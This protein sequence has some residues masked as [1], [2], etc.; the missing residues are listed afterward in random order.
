[1]G[2]KGELKEIKIHFSWITDLSIFDSNCEEFARAGRTRW[3]IENE[4]F[5]TLKNQGY[6]FEHNFGHGYKNLSI[7]MAYLMML[8]FLCDQL[9]ALGCSLFKKAYHKAHETISRLWEYIKSLYTFFPIQI[10]SWEMLFGVISNAEE[11]IKV[12]ALK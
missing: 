4:T 5:N 1:V 9:Q 2:K 12:E 11:W 10:K 8:A 6:N 3:K 7:N